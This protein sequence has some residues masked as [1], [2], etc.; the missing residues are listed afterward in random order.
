MNLVQRALRTLTGWSGMAGPYVDVGPPHLPVA[1]IPDGCGGSWQSA[2]SLPALLRCISLYSD[3]L[4][5]LPRA[6]VRRD[7]RSA[8]ENDTTSDAARAI[9]QTA[10]IDWEGAALACALTGN[11]FL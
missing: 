4:A 6:I 7:A 8:L 3:Q 9:S 11:G 1:E 10:F 5:T 2:V